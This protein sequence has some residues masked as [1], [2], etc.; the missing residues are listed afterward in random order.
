MRKSN[1]RDEGEGSSG[2]G[3]PKRSRPRIKDIARYA[4]VSYSTAARVLSR[5]E[6]YAISPKM[7]ERVLDVARK[8][9]YSTDP[10]A[11]YMRKR[12]SHII[13]MSGVMPHTLSDAAITYRIEL[14][15]RVAGINSS[16]YYRDYNLMLFLRDDQAADLETRLS[17]GIAYMDGLIYVSPTTK[18][19]P[20]LKRLA[21]HVPIVLEDAEGVDE[22]CSVSVDQYGAIASATRLLANRG[23]RRISLLMRHGEEYYHNHIRA[24]AF[25]ETLSAL[26]LCAEADQVLANYQGRQG[27]H[28]AVLAMLRSRGPV[29]GLIVPRDEELVDALDAIEESGLVLGKGV[30]LIS[31]NETE[32]SRHMK[33]GITVVRF[34][35]EQVAR[36]AFELLIRLIEGHIHG[37]EHILVPASIVERQSTTG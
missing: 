15:R 34:P 18:H 3:G 11:R 6:N 32:F 24:K 12:R 13:G 30:K 16:P 17:Q 7:R 20:M 8:H 28:A 35:T 4:G 31:V 27:T 5:N 19:R 29:D 14:N 37:T 33:P 26:G 9:H 1:D 22:L 21:K 2:G 36:E 10:F 25:R 23:C